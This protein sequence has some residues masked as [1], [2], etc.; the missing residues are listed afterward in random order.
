MPKVSVII[1]TFNRPTDL[2]AAIDSVLV[3]GVQDV[4][5]II[6][7]DASDS[8]SQSEIQ[9]LAKERSQVTLIRNKE[10]LGVARSR[11]IGIEYSKADYLL[12]L[13][14]DDVLLPEM[15]LRSLA[16][17]EEEA[18]DA[19]SC[20]CEVT[21]DHLSAGRLNAYNRHTQFRFDLY[22]ITEWPN[23]HLCLYHPQVHTFLI[24]RRSIDDIRFATELNYGEDILF[25]LELANKG[26]S[27]ERI[28]FVGCKYHLH[29]L[30]S[31]VKVVYKDKIKFYQSLLSLFD[32][33]PRVRN[34]CWIKMTV[35]AFKENELQFVQ[36][37]INGLL[38]PGLFL[39][40]L[41][42]YAKTR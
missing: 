32:S 14:D 15:L 1:P 34:L 2:K 6:V 25:W 16:A 31:S 30:N 12:F 40:H 7:D 28:N 27:F 22:P 37:L 11:N 10:N 19:I 24:R 13:D 8:S 18:C 23:E 3:Q 42:Y 4:E 35:V 21:G 20:L 26:L 33:N 29:P 41:K 9:A 39:K 36:W 17:I 38:R 5:I